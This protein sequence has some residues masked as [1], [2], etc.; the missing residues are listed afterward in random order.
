VITTTYEYPLPVMDTSLFTPKRVFPPSPLL[1]ILYFIKLLL[2]K[3]N[4]EL[5]IRE[6][7]GFES[8]KNLSK[9]SRISRVPLAG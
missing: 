7:G 1:E 5:S 9:G 2:V 8:K 6:I 3:Q 4:F